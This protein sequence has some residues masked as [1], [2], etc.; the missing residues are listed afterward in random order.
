MANHTLFR[1]RLNLFRFLFNQET[2]SMKGIRRVRMCLGFLFTFS[3]A[4]WVSSV[5]ASDPGTTVSSLVSE[6][7]YRSYLDDMLYTRFGDDRGFGTEHDLAQA[8]IYSI[9]SG[10]GLDVVLEPVSYYGSTYYNVVGTKWG[11][12]YSGQEYVLGAHYD[13]VNNPGADDNASGTAL[14]LEAARVLSGFDSEY[15]IRFIAFD[16]E[17]QG[18]WGSEQYV[19]DHINDDILAMISTSVIVIVPQSAGPSAAP[20]YARAAGP[21]S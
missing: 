4:A 19:Q 11:T 9:L 12:I 7:S 16:R 6:A 1:H 14:M 2:E 10:F 17:E 5:A 8:N 15:T 21:N 18:L 3:A 13:S 20:S